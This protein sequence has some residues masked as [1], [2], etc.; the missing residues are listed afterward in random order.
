M[1]RAELAAWWARRPRREQ[2]MIVLALVAAPLALADALWGA[3]AARRAQ[4]STQQLEALRERLQAQTL[5]QA[6]QQ[7]RSLT[8]QQLQAQLHERLRRAQEQQQ[9][10]DRRIAEAAR[11][12]EM[13]RALAG[14]LGTARVIALDLGAAAEPVA[15]PGGASAAAAGSSGTRLYRLPITVKV[16]ASWAELQLLLTQIE[17]HAGGLEWT[18]LELDN[19][20]WP[21]IELQLGAHV[22]SREPRWSAAS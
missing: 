15:A 2:L 9:V 19:T 22:L 7:A 17:R 12:P 10:L 5:R 16:S 4:R 11:L 6:E 18:R 21:A 13:L 14:T 3:P 1:K 8:Q 20:Q